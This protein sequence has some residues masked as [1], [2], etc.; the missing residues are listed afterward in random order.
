MTD[1]LRCVSCDVALVDASQA[2]LLPCFH[3][4]CVD[5]VLAEGDDDDDDDELRCPWVL[6][7][8]QEWQTTATAAAD[9]AAS[10]GA[11]LL[12]L[13]CGTPFTRSRVFMPQPP[14]AHQVDSD[15]TEAAGATAT[16]LPFFCRQCD[17]PL[18]LTSVLRHPC[19]PAAVRPIGFTIP[20]INGCAVKQY[21][22]GTEE[23]GPE[24]QAAQQAHEAVQAH[25]EDEYDAEDMD[26]DEANEPQ[27]PAKPKRL[28]YSCFCADCKVPLCGSCAVKDNPHHIAAG[29]HVNVGLGISYFMRTLREGQDPTKHLVRQQTRTLAALLDKLFARRVAFSRALSQSATSSSRAV[30]AVQRQYTVNELSTRINADIKAVEGLHDSLVVQLDLLVAAERVALDA[31]GSQPDVAR[32]SALGR[33][34]DMATRTPF[35]PVSPIATTAA[36]VGTAGWQKIVQQRVYTPPMTLLGTAIPWYDNHGVRLQQYGVPGRDYAT[37]SEPRAAMPV[38]QGDFFCF[39][40]DSHLVWLHQDQRQRVALVR[41]MDGGNKEVRRFR[42]ELDPHLVDPYV[43]E[44]SAD[45]GEHTFWARTA[46]LLVRVCTLTGKVLQT[47]DYGAAL[48]LGPSQTAVAFVVLESG[49]VVFAIGE[50]RA[51]APVMTH[52]GRSAAPPGDFMRWPVAC[53]REDGER[54]DSD[55]FF[56]FVDMATGRTLNDRKQNDGMRKFLALYHH[57]TPVIAIGRDHIA[58]LSGSKG[59]RGLC[60]L[61]STTGAFVSEAD[62]T[63]PNTPQQRNANCVFYDRSSD[64]FF[65]GGDDIIAVTADPEEKI[66]AS[67]GRGDV[68]QSTAIYNASRLA[69]PWKRNGTVTQIQVALD[70]TVA[71]CVEGKQGRNL[72]LF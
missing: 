12:G 44:V 15:T 61:A 56:E 68:S 26:E 59:Y 25:E 70:G 60:K 42:L 1:S 14:Q 2:A 35:A 64:L 7:G 23:D 13:T 3:P 40:S 71:A 47:V 17:L 37:V 55:Y 4:I 21:N 30:D 28:N 31:T 72:L 5:C 39:D 36:L 38:D 22:S 57:G 9:A 19:P 10:E 65:Y 46:S 20:C 32:I 69:A 63:S 41:V 8:G 58:Y 67:F 49:A 33:L 34:I 54:H 53:L 50:T 29:K 51:S 48:R 52:R 18:S 62:L 11:I 43:R 6:T 66:V 24:E 16:G 27:Q 45:A